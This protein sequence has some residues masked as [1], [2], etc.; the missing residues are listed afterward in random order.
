MSQRHYFTN[1]DDLATKRK[2]V[3]FR[4]YNLSF[5]FQTDLGVFAKDGI[6][7]GSRLLIENILQQSPKE[8]I[9]DIGCGYGFMGIV[10]SKVWNTNV[11][12]FDINDR[13]VA[14]AN[15]NIEQNKVEGS[16]IQSDGFEKISKM[17]RLIMCNP[18]I[19]AGKKV[20]YQL[21]EDAYRHLMPDG[22]L[23]IVIRKQHGGESATK[24][25]ASIY[26]EVIKVDKSN[27][28][29]VIKAKK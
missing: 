26:R 23:W 1:N 20:I 3:S 10:V 15:I 8:N 18:P 11:D 12:M 29:W 9:L 25:L 14:L 17:Y 5:S 21:F 6:D 28:F 2:E 27:G 24:Y 4:F 7:Y 16:V 22:E 19:R 13:A